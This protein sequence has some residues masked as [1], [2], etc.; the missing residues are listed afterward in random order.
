MQEPRREA[1]VSGPPPCKITKIQIFLAILVWIPWKII[2][3]T[4]AKD[5][6]PLIV[7]FGS[8]FPSSTRDVIKKKKS[9]QSWSPFDK[10]FFIHAS[11]HAYSAKNL[12]KYSADAYRKM[13]AYQVDYGINSPTLIWASDASKPFFRVS[14]KPDSNQAPQLQRLARNLKIGLYQV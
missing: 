5:D 14:A 1:R 11:T 2:I 10:Y 12:I 8:F 9:F 7:V 6:G 13:C 3:S 4:P